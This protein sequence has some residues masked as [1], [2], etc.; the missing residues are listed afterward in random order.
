MPK[1]LL[2]DSEYKKKQAIAAIDREVLIAERKKHQR[3]MTLRSDST[4]IEVVKTYLA[5]GGNA[6]LTAA[7]TKI[8]FDTIKTW[9]T[10]NWWNQL[11]NDMRKAEKLELSA[12]TKRILDKSLDLVMDR[13]DNGDFF[14]DQKSGQLV[15]KP[16]P[17]R[18]LNKIAVDMIDQKFILDKATE[19]Q[20]ELSTN[21]EKLAKLAER[22]AELAATALARKPAV[23]VTDVVFVEENHAKDEERQA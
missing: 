23:E 14:Y 16:I 8:P 17:A 15:R 18:E 3:K 11:V 12:K 6:T 1:N 22:F 19:E 9:K 10:T 7:A 20:V 4:K 13:L 2:T 5:L 21:E